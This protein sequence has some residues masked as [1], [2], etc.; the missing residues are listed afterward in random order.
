MNSHSC[1]L[2]LTESD[3]RKQLAQEEEERV[4][5]GQKTT[6]HD[7]SPASFLSIGLELEAQQYVVH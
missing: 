1:Q 3:V 2:G 4:R 5:T 7:V 6:L